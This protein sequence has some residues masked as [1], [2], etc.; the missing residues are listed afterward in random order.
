MFESSDFEGKI[1]APLL[2]EDDAF[3]S[4]PIL[5]SISYRIPSVHTLLN[6]PDE[7]INNDAWSYVFWI[8]VMPNMDHGVEELECKDRNNC[9]IIFY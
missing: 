8:T 1:F 9:K 7:F 2:T 5:G 4:S 3:T 6:A